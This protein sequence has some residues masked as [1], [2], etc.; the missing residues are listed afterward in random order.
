L[1][2]YIFFKLK[3]GSSM[4]EKTDDNINIQKEITEFQVTRGRVDNFLFTFGPVLVLAQLNITGLALI[5]ETIYLKFSPHPEIISW[6]IFS[7]FYGGVLLALLVESLA[8]RSFLKK[9]PETFGLLWE[10]D[11]VKDTHN[12]EQ[13]NLKF[14]K[15]INDFENALNSRKRLFSGVLFSILGVYFFWSTGH[16]PHTISRLSD[17]T[18]ITTKLVTLVVNTFA[19]FLPAIVVGYVIGI[20]VWKSIITGIYVRRFSND[21]DLMIQANHPDEAGGLKPLG[22]LIL[23]MAAILIIASLVLSGL[24]IYASY[25]SFSYSETFSRVFLG[26][27]FGLSLIAFFLPLASAHNRMVAEK[28]EMQSLLVKISKRINELEQSTRTN[29]NEMDYKN[30]EEIFEEIDSLSVLYK[31][32]LQV[33]TWPFDRGIFLKFI[34]PQVFSLLSLVGIAEPIVVAIRSLIYNQP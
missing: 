32:T 23:S 6:A 20:S 34:T 24:M 1:R 27:T 31:R 3:E 8:I 2:D 28:Q 15:F 11:I 13:I 4:D 12:E 26:I 30:R 22:D 29:I 9:I 18:D 16:I 19:L 10:T 25:I 14:W 5:I 33:P 7:P 17:G 21:F